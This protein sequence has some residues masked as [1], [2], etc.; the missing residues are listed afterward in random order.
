MRPVFVDWLVRHGWPAWFCPDYVTMVGIATLLASALVLRQAER[1]GARVEVQARALLC[2]YFASL[3]G[4]YLFE[5]IRMIPE[6][7]AQRSILPIALAGRAAYGGL[8]FGTLAPMVYLRRRGERFVDFLDRS[9]LGLGLVFAFVRF[10][11]FLEGCDFGRP[12]SSW[13]GVRFPA[14][15]LAAE[16]HL[17]AGWIPRGAASL[18]VHPTELYEGA[19][20]LLATLLA[21]IPL[22]SGRRDG[23]A[24][25]TW[26]VTYALGRFSL[27]LL[28]GDVERGSYA[29]LSTAQW[30]SV[31]IVAIVVMSVVVTARR[32]PKTIAVVALTVSLFALPLEAHADEALPPPPQQ[33]QQ[34]EQQQPASPPAQ[35][36]QV[37]P[38]PPP[39]EAPKAERPRER[40]VT[41]R[42]ALAPSL[43]LARPDVPSGW[44]GEFDALYR[45]RLAPRTRLDLG[46]EGRR[47]ENVDAVHLSVGIA[48][49]FVFEIRRYFELLLTLVPHHTWFDFKSDFFSDTN[50]YGLRYAFGAQFPIGR[51]ILGVTPLSFT[52]TS[53]LTVGVISQWEPRVWA[54]VSF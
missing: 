38:A 50:A 48:A 51:A 36:V 20:G 21:G 33:Q 53:S 47:Y 44:A 15:S 37:A 28:R 32:R 11:C 13:L 16:A 35:P 45:L 6:A 34:Q 19:V 42:V 49:E 39:Y 30:V 17:A 4:G 29:S 40:V 8:I 5:W 27:E 12:T 46:L 26:L 14:D 2:T 9:T 22:R 18:P 3:L 43:T 23:A 54:G 41:L 7:I 25:A 10:G 24:F 31:A 52:T 1:D